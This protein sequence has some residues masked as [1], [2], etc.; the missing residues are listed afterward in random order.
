VSFLGRPYPNP[1]NPTITI[2]YGIVEQGHVSLYIYNVA[3]QLVKKLVDEQQTPG[4]EGLSVTWAGESDAG[5]QVASGVYF[6]KLVTKNFT[7]T[8]K[9]VLV[10]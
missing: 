4:P 2:E 9:M 10:K 3:G 1:F 8:R 7:Q 6:C 5:E